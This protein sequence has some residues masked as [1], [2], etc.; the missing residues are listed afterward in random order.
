MDPLLEVFAAEVEGHSDDH[1]QEHYS[2]TPQ[3]KTDGQESHREGECAY[4]EPPSLGQDAR[5]MALR[6][7][8]AD[9]YGVSVLGEHRRRERNVVCRPSVPAEPM[10]T[11]PTVS[12]RVTDRT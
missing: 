9:T 1:S 5:L 8:S 10:K 2:P 7:R 4:E 12:S 11:E 3:G 6:K